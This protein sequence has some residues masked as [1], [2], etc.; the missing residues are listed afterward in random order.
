MMSAAQ[1]VKV[2]IMTRYSW[3]TLGVL[4]VLVLF[5]LPDMNASLWTD[6]QR[7]LW[8]AGAAPQYGPAPLTERIE[9]IAE[10]LWQAPSYFLV[11]GEWG[12]VFGW[13]AFAMRTF[14]LFAGL[15]AAA[16][17]YQLG[18]SWFSAEIGFY[19]AFV[20]GV[21]AFYVNYLHDMRTYS[22]NVMLTAL[23][24][25]AYGQRRYSLA[26]YAV[27]LFAVTGLLYTHYFNAFGVAALGLYHLLFR[28]GKP[29]FWGVMVCFAL[30]GV[31]FLPW[32]GVLLRGIALST[33][34]KRALAN[35]SPLEMT[36]NL[37]LMFSNEGRGLLL[38]L[39]FVSL[40]AGIKRRVGFVWFWLLTAA[41]LTVIASRFFPALTETKY[42]IY[43]FPALA[44]LTALG[45][46]ELKRLGVPAAAV[47]V[48]WLASALWNLT[49]P[50]AQERIQ[51]RDWQV[52][53]AAF[54]AALRGHVAPEDAVIFHLA[55]GAEEANRNEMMDFYMYELDIL[56]GELIPANDATPDDLYYQRVRDAV[57]RADRVWLGYEIGRR[58]WRVGPVQETV[59][60]EMGYTR[61]GVVTDERP[62]HLELFAAKP[63]DERG[64][65]YET[66][67][68]H[69]IHVYPLADI[70]GSDTN[71]LH[72]NVGWK[73]SSDV[74]PGTYSL[75]VQFTGADGNLLASRDHG[76]ADNEFG[77]V[78]D[79]VT[80]NTSDYTVNY[81]V[82][83]WQTGERLSPVEGVL[84]TVVRF[85]VP[86][87]Y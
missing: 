74:V 85:G 41:A 25:W 28:R 3:A 38:L 86:T 84:N 23:M 36:N 24:L 16:L 77:C 7:T 31:L 82:Y 17:V 57:A 81:V 19:A 37:L 54:T 46:V 34:D 39:L 76:M 72:L 51:A 52:P 61:C 78:W 50:A 49:D 29:G 15:L 83:N 75:A 59:L 11:M 30:A 63:P 44:L 14:S 26:W 58:S 70:T 80:L 42:V 43:L 21:S 13:S 56:R 12:R 33:E 71:T 48:L 60:P 47:I 40:R 79:T 10:N 8:Y 87:P 2:G 6:E 73:V 27:L 45:T 69:P 18:K 22:L 68:G 65:L 5:A 62:I 64:I 9:R 53:L 1:M 66:P 20:M 55:E 32:A 35:M 4:L 67:D